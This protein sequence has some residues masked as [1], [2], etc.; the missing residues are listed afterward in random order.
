MPNA[1]DAT[2]ARRRPFARVLLAGSL[3][4]ATPA[5]AT[6]GGNAQHV[7]PDWSPDGTTIV[8]GSDEGSSEPYY[9]TLFSIHP[10]GTGLTHLT[11]EHPLGDFYPRW[12][13]DGSRIAFRR[14]ENGN[15]EIFLMNPDGTGQT[16]L[17]NDPGSDDY[18]AW[19]PDGRIGFSR[20]IDGNRELFVM[21]ADGTGQTRLTYTEQDEYYAVW[22]PVGT[23][24]A[25]SADYDEEK[26]YDIYTMNA[27][28]TGRVR[29]TTAP[30]GDA[31]PAWSPDGTRI[32]FVTQ[33]EGSSQVYVMN[34][35]GSGQTNLTNSYPA[36]DEHPS[37]SPD[38][39]RIV[40]SSTR[41]DL[42]TGNDAFEYL[43]VMNA[44][45]SS[46]TRITTPTAPLPGDAL[47][48][49]VGASR[50]GLKLSAADPAIT[51]L[52]SNHS[53]EDPSYAGGSLRLLG[54]GFDET[55]ALPTGGWTALGLDKG[56][57]YRDGSAV[58]GPVT[59]IVLRRGKLTMSGRG[60]GLGFTLATDPAPVDV[61]L[62]TGVKRYCLRFG[63]TQMFSA[64]RR[65]KAKAA[66][67]PAACP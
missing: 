56:F 55:F 37:W 51:F 30:F 66:P 18:P 63:G 22:S 49:T 43:Y 23:R 52:A 41:D 58:A 54:V 21:N 32:A 12:S 1:Q 13:P 48:L 64:G 39:T 62:A 14:T 59:S 31:E 5:T 50:A 36:N 53:P 38:G 42:S 27:D 45:G 24:I 47:S 19:L 9:Y 4:L 40:F 34:A 60:A 35:D 61:T 8:F 28:G 10:D 7:Y 25:L 26:N 46:Q 57:R 16:N 20:F 67:A 6:V 29:L 11:T 2:V 15:A 3:W 65:Y 33:R 44:D 17:T